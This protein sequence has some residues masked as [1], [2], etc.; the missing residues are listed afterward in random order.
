MRTTTTGASY[1][2][3]MTDITLDHPAPRRAPTLHDPALY[4]D[5]I[6]SHLASYFMAEVFPPLTPLAFDPRHPFPLISNRSKNL[7]VGIRHNR[8][9]KFARVKIPDVLPR[10]VQVPSDEG[11]AFAFLE[12][13][14]RLNLHQL[15]PEIDVVDATMPRRVL[16]LLMENFYLL[17]GH[18]YALSMS[19]QAP[20]VNAQQGLLAW[21]TS[22]PASVEAAE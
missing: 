17:E 4:T 21:Y 19:D 13:V 16:K 7:A 2:F 11:R 18:R 1:P 5:K 9:T 12:D 3:L 20:R 6:R 22:R 14:I 8:R 15:F 10:F